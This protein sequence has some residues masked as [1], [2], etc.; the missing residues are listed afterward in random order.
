MLRLRD[1]AVAEA[2]AAN[3]G[4][5]DTGAADT[6]AADTGAADIGAADTGAAD[7][8]DRYSCDSFNSNETA[9]ESV[10]VSGGNR[11]G[12]LSYADGGD[13]TGDGSGDGTGGYAEGGK[14]AVE[15]GTDDVTLA[16]NPVAVTALEGHYS[17]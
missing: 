7:T 6:G 17:F 2:E 15:A 12:T 3:T 4:A 13:G 11:N 5:A 14:I 8:G 10:T 9:E 16:M 1:L